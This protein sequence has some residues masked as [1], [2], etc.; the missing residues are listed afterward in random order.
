MTLDYPTRD[1]IKRVVLAA[2]N[3]PA[4]VLRYAVAIVFAGVLI[5]TIYDQRLVRDRITELNAHW[6]I[7]AT[8]SYWDRP[9]TFY[10]RHLDAILQTGMTPEQAQS[11]MANS[12]ASCLPSGNTD[13]FVLDFPTSLW[14]LESHVIFYVTYDDD[15]QRVVRIVVDN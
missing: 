5:V 3:R 11:A 13:L 14:S 1:A 15:R 7:S 6:H 10:L 4:T 2:V 12:G 8:P 9:T